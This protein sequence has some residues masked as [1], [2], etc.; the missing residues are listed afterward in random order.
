[1]SIV[2]NVWWL[3]IGS[4][5]SFLGF[6]WELIIWVVSFKLDNIWQYHDN[7]SPQ[8]M[9]AVVP[10]PLD[11]DHFSDVTQKM[12][13]YSE[14]RITGFCS[15]DAKTYIEWNILL[16]HSKM[17]LIFFLVCGLF[18]SEPLYICML[19]STHLLKYIYLHQN[20]QF[21]IEWDLY[22]PGCVCVSFTDYAENY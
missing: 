11:T 15:S 8:R 1:M 5:Y 21:C 18:L 9:F 13:V 2:Y 17:D 22:G 10:F 14:V 19:H 16:Y 20:R 7:I 4:E 12:I 6:L 3:Y